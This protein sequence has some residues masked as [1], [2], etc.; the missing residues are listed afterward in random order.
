MLL[1]LT[2]VM[3]FGDAIDWLTGL[4]LGPTGDVREWS[5]MAQC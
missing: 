4:R 2:L 3:T 5:A 1:L